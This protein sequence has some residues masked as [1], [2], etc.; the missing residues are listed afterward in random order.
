MKT[1]TTV[2]NG[3][4]NAGKPHVRLEVGGSRIGNP[5]RGSLLC[6]NVVLQ[7]KSIVRGIACALMMTLSFSS[8]GSEIALKSD[9]DLTQ[10]IANDAAWVGGKQPGPEDVAVFSVGSGGNAANMVPLGADMSWRGIK[11]VNLPNTLYLGAGSTHAITLGDYGI[12]TLKGASNK[13]FYLNAP[14]V[15]SVDQAWTNASGQAF[16]YYQDISGSGHLTYMSSGDTAFYSGAIGLPAGMTL[17][18]TKSFYHNSKNFYFTCPVSVETNTAYY[19]ALGSKVTYAFS[20]IFRSHVVTNDGYFAT[21]RQTAVFT[22]SFSDGDA[23]V[24]SPHSFGLENRKAAYNSQ[25]GNFSVGNTVM[26]MTGGLVSNNVVSLRGCEINLSGGKIYADVSVVSSPSNDVAGVFKQDLNVSGGQLVTPCLRLGHNNNPDVPTRLRVSGGEVSVGEALELGLAET[27]ELPALASFEQTGGTV[28]LGGITLGSPNFGSSAALKQ[29]DVSISLVGGDLYVGAGGVTVNASR[30]TDTCNASFT[31]SGGTYHAAA[32]HTIGLPVTLM[33]D[34]TIDVPAGVVFK[35]R[36]TFTGSGH[37][38]K[39]GAGT[40]DLVGSTWPATVVPVSRAGTLVLGESVTD[41]PEV[42]SSHEAVD[43]RMTVEPDG[44]TELKGDSVTKGDGK[45]DGFVYSLV[46][47][48]YKSGTKPTLGA[49]INGH[50]TVSF[51]GTSDALILSGN[52]NMTWRAALGAFGV[53]VVLRATSGSGSAAETDW[54]KLGGIVS[55]NRDDNRSSWGLRLDEDGHPVFGVAAS[56][57][58]TDPSQL[59]R[60]PSSIF[61][62]RPHVVVGYWTGNGG[63]LAVSVDGV[64]E[65]VPYQLAMTKFTSSGPNGMLGV[66]EEIDGTQ[67]RYNPAGFELAEVR[68]FNTGLSADDQQ[69][70]GIDL[71]EKYDLEWAVPAASSVAV[72]A[73]AILDL[74]SSG[75]RLAAGQAISGQ[76]TVT[77]GPLVFG[78]GSA[79]GSG[80]LTVDSARFVADGAVTVVMPIDWPATEDTVV[81][82]WTEAIHLGQNVA[83]TVLR[84]GQQVEARVKVDPVAKTLIAGPKPGLVLIVR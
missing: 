61:D 11:I 76:G 67:R 81:M 20:D 77:G 47:K 79:L 62:G 39:S 72:D 71:A 33:G 31:L 8:S 10:P 37:L 45:C 21:G 30:W 26:N 84:G 43:A 5:R 68:Y 65:A 80:P 46:S 70:L 28:R 4:P 58:D 54:R 59:V 9:W 16:R 64:R 15:I 82:R 75:L 40:L 44:V 29:A 19:I 7:D 66:G 2:L 50:K 23:I 38:F 14:V 12:Q 49:P 63:E 35:P 53:A 17:Y 41:F 51:D 1:K 25:G 83:F 13:P 52:S 74:G 32:A 3:K 27:D 36:A 56:G 55:A 42:I 78:D 6:K 48:V 57:K 69:K 24:G 34:V 22:M 18:G 73:G 60:H